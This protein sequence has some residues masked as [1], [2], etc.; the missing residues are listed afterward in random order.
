M[1]ATQITIQ[2]T[3]QEGGG[4]LNSIPK[5]PSCRVNRK[6]NFRSCVI[7]KILTKLDLKFKE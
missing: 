3:L 6:K 2:L 1:H 7:K 5:A 4:L